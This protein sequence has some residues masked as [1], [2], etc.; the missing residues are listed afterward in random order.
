[1]EPEVRNQI[2]MMLKS[3]DPEMMDLAVLVFCRE[4]PNFIH[5]KLIEKYFKWNGFSDPG[6]DLYLK[7]MLK[8]IR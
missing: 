6:T 8:C 1:M 5:Y 2:V 7:R 3:G 4:R